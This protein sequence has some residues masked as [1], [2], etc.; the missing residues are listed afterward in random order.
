MHLQHKIRFSKNNYKRTLF[1]Y[2][3]PNLPFL[4]CCPSLLLVCLQQHSRAQKFFKA[5]RNN[6]P[7][8][9]VSLN[10]L[11]YSSVTSDHSSI[12]SHLSTYLNAQALYLF[13]THLRL[14]QLHFFLSFSPLKTYLLWHESHDGHG[15]HPRLLFCFP[16]VTR[17][18]KKLDFY[19]KNLIRH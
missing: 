2:K 15:G 16:W 9:E 13:P 17:L 18:I 7:P 10:H 14:L 11:S 5:A 3:D 4:C 19:N 6:L 1:Y 8:L 12:L